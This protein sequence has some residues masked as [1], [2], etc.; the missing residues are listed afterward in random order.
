MLV[1]G[2]EDGE[3]GSGEEQGEIRV[4]GEEGGEGESWHFGVKSE[5]I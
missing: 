2:K 3:V 5:K 4:A 1:C